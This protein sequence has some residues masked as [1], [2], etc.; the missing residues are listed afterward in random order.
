MSNINIQFPT[1]DETVWLGSIIKKQFNAFL[2]E[3]VN[4]AVGKLQAYL[5]GI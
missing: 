2:K 5:S 1:H 3:N 4:I